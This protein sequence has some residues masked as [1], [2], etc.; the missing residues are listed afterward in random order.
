MASGPLE[1]K[2]Q[3][4]VNDQTW[5]LGSKLWFYGRLISVLTTY[6]AISPALT[7]KVMIEHI[8]Y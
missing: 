8:D 5:V 4:V 3:L 1:L 2:F 7:F 6:P